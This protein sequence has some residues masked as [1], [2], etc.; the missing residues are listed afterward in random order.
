M[1]NDPKNLAESSL[2]PPMLSEVIAFVIWQNCEDMESA[3]ELSSL[4]S[5]DY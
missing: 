1:C 5:I 2:S 3:D 4:F